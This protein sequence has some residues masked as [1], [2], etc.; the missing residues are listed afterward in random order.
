M[1]KKKTIEYTLMAA[2]LVLGF[3]IAFRLAPQPVAGSVTQGNEYIA[4]NFAANNV[5]GA[6]T[7][8]GAL[9]IGAGSLAQVVIEG[10]TTGTLNFYNATTSDALFRD[11]SQSTSSILIA[12]LPASLVAGTYTFDAS[13]SRGLFMDLTGTMPTTTVL[14]R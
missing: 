1:T 3:V 7:T 11:A 14:I 13:Y 10:A 6:S 9:K 8:P 2:V 4:R 12:S 5:Y